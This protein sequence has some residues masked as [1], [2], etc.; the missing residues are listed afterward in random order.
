M[1]RNAAGATTDIEHSL[2]VGRNMLQN[3]LAVVFLRAGQVFDNR[4]D[5]VVPIAVVQILRADEMPS[6]EE[7]G[8]KTDLLPGFSS[9]APDRLRTNK[10]RHLGLYSGCITAEWLLP[11]KRA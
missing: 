10:K 7:T 11:G 9:F 1:G 6:R 5:A 8:D 2:G 3:E 4:L